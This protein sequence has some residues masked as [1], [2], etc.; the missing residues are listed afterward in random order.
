MKKV[1]VV[2][3]PVLFLIGIS[4]ILGFYCYNET[5]RIH[6]FFNYNN[7]ETALI[8]EV[9]AQ[10]T[11]D[12]NL[13]AIS[14]MSKYTIN[15]PYIEL[16]PYKISPLSAIIIFGSTEEYP[17]DVYIN[18]ELFTKME[19]SKIHR[20]PIYGLLEN[21]NN[22]IKLVANNEEYI[23]YI[24]TKPS[25]IKYPINVLEA[26]ED[27]SSNTIYFTT[28]SY[29]TWLTG[30]D[31]KGRLRFYLTVD[32]RM[33]VEWLPNGHFLIGTTE[34][35]FAENFLGFVEMDYLGKIYN[36][37][38]TEH[39]FS[40]ESQVLSN[41]NYM[42]TG[43]LKPVY[44]E[45][46][47]VYEM[48]PKTG[49]TVSSL[50]FYDLFKDIDDTFPDKYLSQAAVRNGFYY[51]E[52]THEMIV[53]F[54]GINTVFCV[55]YQTKKLKWVFTSPK[56]PLFQKDVW[57][58]YLVHNE[59]GRYPWG[60]HSP[61]IT[62]DGYIAIFN[63]GYDRYN[64]FE[65]GG[66]DSVLSYKNNYSRAEIYDI[67]N[68]EA[69]L[70]W[71][72]DNDKSLFSH[73]YGSIRVLENYHKLIDFGYVLKDEYRLN[74]KATLSAAEMNP[75][76]IYSLIIELDAYDNVVFK[77][78]CEEGKYRVFKH[79]LYNKTTSNLDTTCHI[80]NTIPTSNYKII[81]LNSINLNN[82][83]EWIFTSD[84]T[85]NTFVTTYDLTTSDELTLYFVNKTGKI[86]TYTYKEKDNKQINHIFNLELPKGQ[87]AL[88]IN[89]NDTVYNANKV[90]EY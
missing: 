32:Y 83:P 20:I 34:G 88:F 47:L 31:S 1:V 57:K 38:T 64:G 30:W 62:S 12:S 42:I 49:N 41:G 16:N 72:Y 74:K 77:A 52:V 56:N 73:Q 6:N 58:P 50:D 46:Q 22:R 35:E 19:S 87:Y 8:S 18:D 90:I 60:Q 26:R 48:D 66:E 15:K 55:D 51:D 67:Q 65:A 11:I 17:V 24:P 86:Y 80:F 27:I 44:V 75:D 53:S 89:L 63:N 43:G 81:N 59:L 21:Y 33:D 54:R 71:E 82:R 25:N 79:D 28:A 76:N 69:K 4:A 36:Y 23:Y 2:L 70:I 61:Q 14:K 29:S 78:T 10:S 68:K 3:I 7:K 37:Y 85:K 39:G 9:K 13:L 84:F 45:H 40:F 5:K